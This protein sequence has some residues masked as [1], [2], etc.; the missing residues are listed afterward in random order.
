[1]E[2]IHGLSNLYR[3]R[4]E[5][6][7]TIGNFDG[8]HLG[9]KLVL[10]QLKETAKRFDLIST[11]LIFEPQPMEYFN[12][13]TSPSR[14]TRLREKLQQFSNYN[15]DRVVCLKFNKE[16][17]NLSALDFIDDILLKGLFAKKIIVGDDFRFSRNREGNYQYL[18]EVSHE[19]NFE[20]FKTGSYV[21]NGERVSS[22]MIRN[23]LAKGDI[24]NA[25]HYLGRPYSIS[26]RVVH[27]DKRGKKI[28]FPTINIELHRNL[29]PVSGIFAGYVHGIDEK[30]LDA[31]VYIGSRPVY[32]G[33]RILLEAHILEFDENIYGRHIRVELIDKLRN[34]DHITSEKELIEQIK[35]DIDETKKCLKKYNS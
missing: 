28:G 3:Q 13:E 19:K 17:A 33:G 23:T 15:I 2:F 29:S 22:T 12:P 8:V 24:T 4:K 20:V 34:D 16:L 21:E 25:N 1:M 9:H 7:A 35:K 6:V 31:V 30:S 10:E 14:L 5:C 27:G 26:G 32:K 11:V 18:L